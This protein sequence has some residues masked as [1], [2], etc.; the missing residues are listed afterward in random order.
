MDQNL[1]LEILGNFL[2]PYLAQ[3]YNMYEGILHQDN[4]PKHTAKKCKKFLSNSGINWVKSPSKSPD[5]N[6]IEMLWHAMKT[7][8]RK[9]FCKTPDEVVF[10]IL[11]WIDTVTPEICKK[12]IDNL[13]KVIKIVIKNKGGWSNH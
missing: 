1:Y 2:F 8:I 3:H 13:P 12:Y 5:L 6:P 9:R 7:F 10:A 4:D 11:D